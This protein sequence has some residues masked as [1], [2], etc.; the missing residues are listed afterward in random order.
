MDT[1]SQTLDAAAATATG[2]ASSP[3]WVQDGLMSDIIGALR[4]VHDPEIPVNLY[5][6]GLIYRIDV[7]DQGLV[8]IDMT[9]TAPGCPVASEMLGW[10]KTAVSK[11][12]SCLRSA[13]GS[14]KDV[15]RSQAGTRLGIGSRPGISRQFRAL[16]ATRYLATRGSGG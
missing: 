9:L 15:G 4:T 6:L 16:F 8:E 11:S 3:G 10:V 12:Q 7:K 1:S 13:L 5:D 14:V 2:D